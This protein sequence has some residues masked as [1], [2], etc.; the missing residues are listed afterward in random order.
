MV[1]NYKN[2][3]IFKTMHEKNSNNGKYFK[4]D[5]GLNPSIYNYIYILYLNKRFIHEHLK[6][7]FIISEKLEGALF[8]TIFQH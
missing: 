5:F 1:S 2:Y 7:A 4:I 8:F 3:D 6:W